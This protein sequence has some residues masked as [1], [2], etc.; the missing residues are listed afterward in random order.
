MGFQSV[1]P[2]RINLFGHIKPGCLFRG[3]GVEYE[4]AFTRTD[5]VRRMRGNILTMNFRIKSLSNEKSI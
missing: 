1:K 2:F 3:D 5:R 4:A